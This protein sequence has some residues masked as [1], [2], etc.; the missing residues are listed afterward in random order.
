MKKEWSSKIDYLLTSRYGYHNSDYLAFLVKKVWK[1]ERP[2]RVV[3]FGCGYG[4][5][6]L[7]L[8]PFFPEGSEYTGVDESEELLEKAKEIF[9]KLD[10]R[11]GFICEDATNLPI[12]YSSFDISM[13][14]AFLMHQSNPIVALNEMKRVTKNGGWVITCE[15]NWNAVNALQHI[16]KLEKSEYA[17]LGFLQKLFERDRLATGI[18]GNIGVKMPILLQ[19]AGL[20]NIG[21]RMTDSCKC[22]LP[23][24]KN[25]EQKRIYD[26]IRSD[27]PG[28][29][30]AEKK[31]K[32]IK[33]FVD[34]GFSEGQAAK[35]IARE[36]L[37]T[38]TIDRDGENLQIIMPTTMIFSYGTVNKDE[39]NQALQRTR[40]S[41]AAEL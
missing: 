4:Y 22:H 11:T 10:Y 21:A 38:D 34:R 24:I 1:I 23:P 7:E 12:E 6:G 29:I 27:M 41:R 14:H 28:P 31:V 40:P 16:N 20:I 26:S 5:L 19:E 37:I 2:S 36:K 25:E 33:H 15:A 17:D 18:D 32:M 3:D 39:P 35:Q 9:S 8:L 13:C 30:D